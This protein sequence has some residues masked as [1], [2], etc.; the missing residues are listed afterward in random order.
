MEVLAVPAKSNICERC[1]APVQST[2]QI[3]PECGAPLQAD[4]SSQVVDSVMHAELAQANVLRLRGERDAAEKKCLSILKRYPNEPEAHGLLGELSADREDYA[5]AIE[6]FELA[7]DLNPNSV[8]DRARL[9]ELRAK[10]QSADAVR[11]EEQLGLPPQV[12]YAPWIAAIVVLIIVVIGIAAWKAPHKSQSPMKGGIVEAPRDLT[13]STNRTLS[14][15]SSNS[16]NSTEGAPTKE[17][18]TGPVAFSMED[19][20]LLQALAKGMYGASILSVEEDP[21]DKALLV[22]FSASK[23]DEARRAGAM[24]AKDALDRSPE[25]LMVTVRGVNA[26]QIVFVADGSRPKLSEIE[27]ESNQDFQSGND[28]WISSFLQREWPNPPPANATPSSTNP[29][30]ASTP[31]GAFSGNANS[32]QAQGTGTTTASGAADSSSQT[33]T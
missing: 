6:W 2:D 13:P 17:S 32:A 7:L 28:A 12:N 18:T 5:R 16:E 21:R 19:R 4:G 14:D 31:S 26:D 24:I 30:S 11:T 27:G 20:T 15:D 23:P 29:P 9:E 33:R 3:C 8:K 22:T 25:S 10:V 1:F